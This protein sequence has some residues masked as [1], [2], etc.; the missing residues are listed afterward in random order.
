MGW[1]I[2]CRYLVNA[3]QLAKNSVT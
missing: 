1:P 2:V 3:S